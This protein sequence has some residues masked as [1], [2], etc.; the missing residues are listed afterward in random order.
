VTRGVPPFLLPNYDVVTASPWQLHQ[1]SST[2]PLPAFLP[3]WDYSTDLHLSR[4]IRIDAASARR[5]A[6][7]PPEAPLVVTVEWTAAASQTSDRAC[8]LPVVDGAEVTATADIR[9]ALLGGALILTTR[10]V[11]GE[12]TPSTEPFVAQHAGDVL[13]EDTAR[14]ELQGTAG[15]LP[16]YVVDFAQAGFDRD[17]RWHIELPTSLSEPAAAAVRLYLN[18]ADTEV[19][20]AAR[21][22]AAP[23]AAQQRILTWMESDLTSRLVD[24]ALRA[25]W[26]V[27]LSPFSVATDRVTGSV[28]TTHKAPVPLREVFEVSTHR[29]R[30]LVGATSCR[31]R[32]APCTH[33]VGHHAHRHPRG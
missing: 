24:A 2:L 32:P 20:N 15:R 23:T 27:T 17:A 21:K 9:G 5:E 3:E 30:S 33:R 10:L 11:L 19:V 6:A 31:T 29:R 16:T 4:Q 13:Y 14:T 1:D 8:R 25:E 12:D 22:A 18:S 26:R 7:L 28:A